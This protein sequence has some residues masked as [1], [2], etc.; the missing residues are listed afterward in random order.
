MTIIRWKRLRTLRP[1][2]IEERGKQ[3]IVGWGKHNLNRGI[4]FY[5]LAVNESDTVSPP[6]NGIDRCLCKQWGTRKVT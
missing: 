1:A 5:S 2:R 6:L 4:H 3:L